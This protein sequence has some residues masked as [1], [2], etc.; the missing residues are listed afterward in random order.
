MKNFNS[1]FNQ[2]TAMPKRLAMVLTVLFTIGVGSMLGADYEQI[3][4]SDI[5]TG[6]VIIIVGVKNGITY[7]MTNTGA[8]PTPTTV[9]I[10]ND[11]ISTNA[12][13]VTFTATNNGDGTV[14]F[15]S[16]S[17]GTLYCTN[18]NNGVKIGASTSN[19]KFS[20][21][22]SVNRLKNDGV[23]RWLGI[24]NTQDWRCYTTASATNI[25]GTATYFYRKVTAVVPSYTITATSNNN[26]HGT[27]SVSGN[28]ITAEPADCYQVV[29]GEGGYSILSG[30]ATVTH[31]GNSNTLTVTASSD[32]SIQVNFEKKPVNTYID[33][34][35]GNEEQELCGSHTTP[36]LTDKTQATTGTCEQQHWHF[37]GWVTEANKANPTDANI[38]KAGTSVTANGTTYYAVWA[39]G[40]TTNGASTSKQ[41]SF[42][43]TPSNFNSTSYAANNNEKTSTAK[44]SDGSTLSVKWTSYQVMLQSSVMQWQSGKG[45]IY[46][47]TDLGT[48]NSIIVD[49]ELTQKELNLY[50]ELS[51]VD[52]VTICAKDSIIRE[53]DLILRKKEDYYIELNNSI[54]ANLKR[55]KRKYQIAGGTLVGA[56][57]VLVTVIL[58][59]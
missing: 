13:N 24:Y 34:V 5:K 28:T 58:C 23:S 33:N 59:K 50:K 22:T 1:I 26:T 57:V 4:F 16:T 15:V 12:T 46:N 44:A 53:K 30:T 47:S 31:T 20:F 8:P 18:T 45:Y 9:S 52:S 25:S 35:Q 36:S 17:S 51:V 21:D 14:T 6:D 2:L 43:I 27:V 41:Y 49:Y 7:A 56:V 3:A 48:I 39:K 19:T 32:C 54:Q 37:M 38:V 10:A 40:E 29:S 11:K 42:D 55:E